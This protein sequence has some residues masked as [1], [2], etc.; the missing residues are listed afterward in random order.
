V[1]A[2]GHRPL[3]NRCEMLRRDE[4]D[5]L[6]I[7]A[8]LLL[9]F[10]LTLC[11]WLFSG[12]WL[13]ARMTRARDDAASIN[14]R[15]RHAQ[16]L[17]S[18]AR[19]Q[20][21]LGSVYVRDALLDPGPTTLAEYRRQLESTYTAIDE[22]LAG[23]VPIIDTDQERSR[24]MLLRGEIDQLR[25]TMRDVLDD[26][27]PLRPLEARILLQRR[28]V[29]KRETVI[30][31]SEEAQSLN[32][33]A[34]LTQQ[35]AIADVYTTT[36]HQVWLQLSLAL[37]ASAAIGLFATRYVGGL[38]D[39]LR[40]GRARDADNAR[41][42][43]RLSAKLITAQEEERRSIARELHD[44]VGQVLMAIKVEL[45]LAQRAL[46]H[47]GAPAQVLE[48]ARGLTDN[49]L[50]TVR[51]LS[52]LLHPAVLDDLGLAAAVDSYLREFSRRHSIRVDLLQEGM[53][54]RLTRE[55]EIT[56]Y[57]VIQEALTNIVKHSNA[58]SCRVYLQRLRQT[59]LITIE[60]DGVG[61]DV[62]AQTGESRVGLGLLGVRERVTRLRG[63]M[64]LESGLG[65]GTRLTLELPIPQMT[66]APPSPEGEP[67]F[68]TT[69]SAP[70][71]T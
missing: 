28:I 1:R 54:E 33:E 64:R 37:L 10:G 52:H 50:H 45:G 63:T 38:E 61:F 4:L 70:V 13:S 43:Q 21:L 57:R 2:D 12:Y 22:A 27:A 55:I 69:A 26:N 53:N 17:L 30:R 36:Q 24:I 29:P 11:L 41:D 47:H 67:A 15:Y 58:T 60:D 40:E 31:I 62:A 59:V 68:G 14:Q 7:K 16:E 5:G 32:R 49:A 46:D 48:D 18:T 8:A 20:V 25:M 44:E 39:R 9:G 3:Y 19:A 23:Y 65:K 71:S 6:T 42:L 34:F 56:A 35:A 66:D 51:D